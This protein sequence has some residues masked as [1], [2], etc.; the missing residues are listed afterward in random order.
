VRDCGRS[1]QWAILRDVGVVRCWSCQRLTDPAG[2]SEGPFSIMLEPAP[3]RMF[4]RSRDGVAIM[5]PSGNAVVQLKS[6]YSIYL[7][8][9]DFSPFVMFLVIGSRRDSPGSVGD[10]PVDMCIRPIRG[11]SLL[12]CFGSHRTLESERWNPSLQVTA[13]HGEVLELPALSLVL[14]IEMGAKAHVDLRFNADDA[15]FAIRLDVEQNLSA[16]RA[17]GVQYLALSTQFSTSHHIAIGLR[18]VRAILSD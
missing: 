10:K 14:R 7:S 1:T 16:D 4:V 17:E 5:I 15:P 6:M 12:M 18:E 11:N 3:P 9:R 2:D 13:E 8:L